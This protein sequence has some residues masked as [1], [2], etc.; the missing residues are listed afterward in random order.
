MNEHGEIQDS[1]YVGKA[2]TPVTRLQK[3]GD[4][5]PAPKCKAPLDFARSA[6]G[7]YALIANDGEGSARFALMQIKCPC[8][9]GLMG[10]LPLRGGRFQRCGRPV[11]DLTGTEF[12]PTLRGR[13]HI[14]APDAD[15]HPVTHL[16]A[17]LVEGHWRCI[18]LDR[19]EQQTTAPASK[20]TG[21]K[22]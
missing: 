8:G 9:C 19:F 11:F 15:G 13:L 2:L 6:D 16:T 14:Y 22:S 4:Q 3:P 17:K 18:Y 1:P 5:M 10:N 7:A 12:A 20:P 21:K